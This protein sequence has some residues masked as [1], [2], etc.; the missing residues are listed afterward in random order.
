M[1]CTTCSSSLKVG[2]LLEMNSS[3]QCNNL[4]LSN[5]SPNEHNWYG[6]NSSAHNVQFVKNLSPVEQLVQLEVETFIWDDLIC[7]ETFYLERLSP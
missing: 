6:K 1:Y 4:I 7:K 5:I 3:L 2:H